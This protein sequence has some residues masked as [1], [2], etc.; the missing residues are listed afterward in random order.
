MLDPAFALFL[1]ILSFFLL[2]QRLDAGALTHDHGADVTKAARLSGIHDFQ[3]FDHELDLTVNAGID[4]PTF[5][6]IFV[7]ASN[8]VSTIRSSNNLYRKLRDDQV[9]KKA[10]FLILPGF[11]CFP[12]VCVVGTMDRFLCPSCASNAVCAHSVAVKVRDV[13]IFT[14]Q[15]GI[16]EKDV[17]K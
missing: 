15:Q 14:C 10:C 8:V 9:G 12:A 1:A 4:C 13:E 2:L 3:C 11:I 6:P 17:C 16:R 7:K 5:A